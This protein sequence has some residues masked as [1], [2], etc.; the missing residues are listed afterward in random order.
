MP[1]TNICTFNNRVA[2]V[3]G[4]AGNI[5]VALCRRLAAH[6]VGIAAADLSKEI[7][8]ER[9]AGIG[10][11]RTYQIDVRS[12]DSVREAVNSAIGDFGHIVNNN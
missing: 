2:F 1:L 9:L 12:L 7:L 11:L 8:D 6:G 4:A 5:G 10:N 3:T